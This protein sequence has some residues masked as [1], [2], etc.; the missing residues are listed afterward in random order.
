MTAE[1]VS[2]ETF[3][4]TGDNLHRQYNQLPSWEGQNFREVIVAVACELVQRVT[5]EDIQNTLSIGDAERLFQGMRQ[6][7]SL[8]CSRLDPSQVRGYAITLVELS[9]RYHLAFWFQAAAHS[10]ERNGWRMPFSTII[11]SAIHERIKRIENANRIRAFLERLGPAAD[12]D[13]PPPPRKPDPTAALRSRADLAPE[14]KVNVLKNYLDYA[15]SEGVTTAYGTTH[16]HYLVYHRRSLEAAR[17]FF[18]VNPRLT[19]E[20]LGEFI[21]AFRDCLTHELRPQG[22]EDPYSIMRNCNDLSYLLIMLR[23]L[24]KRDE[25]LFDIPLERYLTK[26]ELFGRQFNPSLIPGADDPDRPPLFKV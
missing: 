23:H 6:P 13:S 22:E 8:Y 10:R 2:Q 9:L 4:S 12:P 24:R 7:L 1:T 17:R 26:K 25:W 19:V 18:Q 21:C 5:D 11:G 16:Y 20:Q 15:N 3:G 14:T